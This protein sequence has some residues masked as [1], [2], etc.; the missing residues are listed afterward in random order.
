[1]EH[2]FYQPDSQSADNTSPVG[3]V[4]ESGERKKRK[5]HRRHDKKQQETMTT[6]ATA[7]ETTS[8]HERP[9]TQ[10]YTSKERP[11]ATIW[12]REANDAPAI[13]AT[14]A[15]SRPDPAPIERKPEPVQK[16]SVIDAAPDLSWIN[17][18]AP[19]PYEDPRFMAPRRPSSVPEVRHEEPHQPFP[20]TR[21]YFW[22]EPE[23]TQSTA[24]AHESLPS[25]AQPNQAKTEP[26]PAPEPPAEP[27]LPPLQALESVDV[28]PGSVDVTESPTKFVANDSQETAPTK[29]QSANPQSEVHAPESRRTEDRAVQSPV[30]ENNA[31]FESAGVNVGDALLVVPAEAE[32]APADDTAAPFEVTDF[33]AIETAH[34]I[35][36][37]RAEAISREAWADLGEA[38]SPSAPAPA[39]VPPAEHS[40]DRNELLVISDSIRVDGVNV[41]EM[42]LAGRLDEPGLRRIVAAYMRGDE[43]LKQLIIQELTRQQMRFE[44]DPQLR[45]MPVARAKSKAK[46]GPG[47]AKRAASSIKNHTKSLLDADRARGGTEKIAEATQA[48]LE[49]AHDLFSASDNA[50]RNLGIAAIVVIY[51]AIIVVLIR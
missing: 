8:A 38:V 2:K 45:D 10:F 47:K 35:A 16:K 14:E 18:F 37:P 11:T 32:L 25:V 36:T 42:F 41:H 39:E 27:E 50:G 17:E 12:T 33:P 43:N 1:M 46:V 31:G 44:R 24:K 22:N 28:A 26:E 49:K 29:S 15:P 30:M 20:P 34:S 4:G 40:M 21:R 51:L 6:A 7:T 5:R 9:G 23:T 19:A 3:R 13:A 48:T